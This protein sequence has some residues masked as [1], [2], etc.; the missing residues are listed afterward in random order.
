[1]PL[2][3]LCTVLLVWMVSWGNAQF[4]G[5]YGRSAYF[6]PITFPQSPINAG[7]INNKDHNV[8]LVTR[9]NVDLPQADDAQVAAIAASKQISRGSEQ[10]SFDMFYV[11]V[12]CSLQIHANQIGIF[13]LM[14]SSNRQLP[15]QYKITMQIL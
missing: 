8:P 7:N 1:M 11:S 13:P 4:Y 2:Q 12:S 10:F 5:T 3:I 15:M 14:V 6:A 9:V